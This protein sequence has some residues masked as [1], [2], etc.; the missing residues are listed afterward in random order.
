MGRVGGQATD[1]EIAAKEILRENE[2]I[3]SIL[4]Q[5]TGQSAEK[6]EHDMDRDFYMSASD[7][8][9]YGIIDEILQQPSRDGDSGDSG[10]NNA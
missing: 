1:I 10:S 6:I 4:I 8:K 2:I 5:N 3:R 7:A 9:A